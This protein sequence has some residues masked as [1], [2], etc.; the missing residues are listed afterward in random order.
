MDKTARLEMAIQYS[1]Y[2]HIF[3]IGAG[4][5]VE[6][7]YRKKIEYQACFTDCRCN[8]SLNEPVIFEENRCG[9]EGKC[10]GSR[11]VEV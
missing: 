3:K 2:H 10:S 7:E 11:I 1:L 8:R 4:C 5:F 6:V 9:L